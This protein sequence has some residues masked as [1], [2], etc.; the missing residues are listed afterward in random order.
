MWTKGQQRIRGAWLYVYNKVS[1]TSDLVWVHVTRYQQCADHDRWRAIRETFVKAGSRSTQ[2]FQ[3]LSIARA[4]QRP[5]QPVVKSLQVELH[6]APC[7]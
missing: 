4:S 7:D 3:C 6:T 1:D 5:V 2:V